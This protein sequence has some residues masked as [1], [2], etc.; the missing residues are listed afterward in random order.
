MTK[1]SL[2]AVIGLVRCY[3]FYKIDNADKKRM[4]HESLKTRLPRVSSGSTPA[5]E[6]PWFASYSDDL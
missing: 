5:S 2:P 6:Q 1:E 3:Y 4:V